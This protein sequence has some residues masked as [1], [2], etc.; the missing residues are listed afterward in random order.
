MRG[1]TFHRQPVR[2]REQVFQPTLPVRGATGDA[3]VVP[4]R[5]HISTHAPRAG[6]D[7]VHDTPERR[8]KGFQPTLPVRGATGRDEIAAMLEAISTH[9]PRAGSDSTTLMT[10][11]S[12]FISTHAPRAGSDDAG[13]GNHVQG[14]DFNPRSPC[15]E[16]LCF[17]IGLAFSTHFNPRSPCGERH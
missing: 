4:C 8:Q 15:G 17:A 16:R 11:R 3:R 13:R 12:L 7:T 1:A 2:R 9:A 5:R 14:V 6:S 10:K